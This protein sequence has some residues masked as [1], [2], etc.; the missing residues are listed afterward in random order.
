MT[1]SQMRDHLRAEVKKAGSMRK[2]AAQKGYT[3]ANI[4][5]AL[6]GKH[7]ISSCLAESIGFRRVVVYEPIGEQET[8]NG[9]GIPAYAIDLY[10]PDPSTWTAQIIA[11]R[12]EASAKKR[13]E[14]E[15]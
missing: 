11:N 7:M 1:E 5:S 4:S 10:G 8:P 12:K 9:A 15:E 13:Y 6:S 2:F 3:H 14:G